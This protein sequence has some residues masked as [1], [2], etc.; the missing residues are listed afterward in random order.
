MKRYSNKEFRRWI[1]KLGFKRSGETTMA[2]G[3]LLGV[4][5]R[6]SPPATHTWCYFENFSSPSTGSRYARYIQ[7]GFNGPSGQDRTIGNVDASH[8][9]VEA[10]SLAKRP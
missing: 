9:K 10:S 6:H 2:D 1:T 4:W 5:V 8:L 3:R 7:E